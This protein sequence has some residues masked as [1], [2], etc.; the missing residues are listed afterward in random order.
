MSTHQI[1]VGSGAISTIL[2]VYSGIPYL[3]AIVK[4]RT[5]PHQ[6][7][8]FIF[9][10]MN[11]I[12]VLSQYLKGGR[13]SILI[14]LVFFIYSLI[15]GWLSLTRG[16]RSTSKYDWFLFSFSIL[17]III[18]ILTSNASIAIWL[19]VFIDIFATAMTILKIKARPD[20]EDPYPWVIG[21]FAYI[22]SCIALADKGLGVLYVR[23]IYGLISDI[24]VAA[25]AYYYL[26]PLNLGR[27]NNK[28]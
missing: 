9:L 21:S 28:P 14:S 19:T 11:G 25:A 27:K 16:I 26:G 7:S 10:I 6:L 15:V 5:K 22:F 3:R 12:I 17:T 1:V 13:A 8:S 4:G 23:P 18:W 2:A 24:L 20:S